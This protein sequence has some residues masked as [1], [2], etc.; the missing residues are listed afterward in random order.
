M[1]IKGPE[2]RRDGAYL[3]CNGHIT[4][5][6][7]GLKAVRELKRLPTRLPDTYLI[8]IFEG[9]CHVVSTVDGAYAPLH[10]LWHRLPQKDAETVLKVGLDQALRHQGGLQSLRGDDRWVLVIYKADERRGAGG[11]GDRCAELTL[12]VD[13]CRHAVFRYVTPQDCSSLG[14]FRLVF[15]RD[16]KGRRLA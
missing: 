12:G 9:L 15:A 16:G 13:G 1:V 7:S 3:F 8:A 11:T 6:M 4:A 2:I 5:V 14:T 10:R